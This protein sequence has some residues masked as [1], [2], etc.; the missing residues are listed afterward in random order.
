MNKQTNISLAMTLSVSALCAIAAGAQTPPA[1]PDEAA[2]ITP[3]QWFA[4]QPKPHYK[5]GHT[6]PHLTRY[7]WELDVAAEQELAEHW[8]YCLQL[9][10]LN[11]ERVDHAFKDPKS[12]EGQRVALTLSNPK[13]YPLAVILDRGEPADQ[14]PEAFL[15]DAAGKL[16]NNQQIYSPIAPQIAY[17][18]MAELRAAP[19]RALRAKVPITIVLNGGEYGL[20]IPG[21]IRDMLDKDPKLKAAQGGQDLFSFV[22]KAKGR[23]STTIAEAVRKAV[24]DRQL[25][26]YYNNGNTH[27]NRYGDWWLWGTE[28]S[29][30]KAAGDVP[31]NEYYY[32][33]FNSG[34]L[35]DGGG[36]D[37]LTQAL[38][39][40][41]YQIPMGQ[42]NS[43]DWLTSGWVDGAAE[44]AGLTAPVAA[45]SND[46]QTA[47][48]LQGDNVA[49][50]VDPNAGE[51]SPMN[52]YTGFLKCLFT[53]GTLG[54]NAGYYAFPNGGFTGSFRADKPRQW[55]IQM[56]RLSHVQSL[57]SYVE[58][59][60]RKGDLLPGDGKHRWSG[61][62]P[63]YEFGSSEPNVRIVARKTVT[64]KT[65]TNKSAA[66]KSTRWLVTAW[67][68]D[69][70]AR[71]TKVTIPELGQL[72]LLARPEGSVYRVTLQGGKP[73]LLLL[74]PDGMT[75]TVQGFA[76]QKVTG[77]QI[78]A[79]WK[80]PDQPVLENLQLHF[81]AA[82]GIT[83]DDANTVLSWKPEG[84]LA[85]W[86]L[87]APPAKGNALWVKNA[88]N[89]LPAVRLDGRRLGLVT[90]A[91]GDKPALVPGTV[92]IFAVYASAVPQAFTA[93]DGNNNQILW[94]AT[95]L[96]FN[97][98]V[99]PVADTQTWQMRMAQSNLSK[100]P[101]YFALGGPT[102]D[103]GELY[104][105][106]IFG[107]D[108]AEILVYNGVL[109]PAQQAQ[110]R[111]Y[112]QGKY[113]L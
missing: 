10:Y 64:N 67:A 104:D 70:V 57:F 80:A 99:A 73:Q 101:P 86:T 88:V 69:G 15:H 33:H 11:Q 18:K 96:N 17:D 76:P 7:G 4:A 77:E 16:I 84:A 23:E 82:Q 43:Y 36:N 5:P 92:T 48:K 58:D 21:F 68:A 59:D 75:P 40:V 107:G 49:A 56:A 41:G 83:K 37:M 106:F 63:S 19:L 20:G 91:L 13:K 90:E 27:R 74:D 31:G 87:K 61:D 50:L 93:Q 66:N 29:Y 42:K 62:Q 6:M 30:M 108:I 98:G 89:G 95:G 105:Q 26:A 9:G 38:N 71:P 100:A 22:S 79:A 52:L 32:K 81:D 45:P 53:T 47:P 109:P 1:K 2:L 8:N 111:L 51:L 35:P 28:G 12:F 97:N 34:Y 24:P 94:T 3:A 103:N 44:E 102:Y 65:V 14:V 113:R 72:T 60:L 54:G 25:Y 78:N 112:L 39:A 110:T 55:A 85:H 46:G